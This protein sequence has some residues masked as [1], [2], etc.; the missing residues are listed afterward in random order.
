M[1]C[2]FS[3]LFPE[4]VYHFQKALFSPKINFI[5]KKIARRSISWLVGEGMI[6]LKESEKKKLNPFVVSNYMI[7][8]LQD[9]IPLA[10]Q[11]L[12]K[13]KQR[14]SQHHI[15]CLTPFWFHQDDKVVNCVCF[16]SV[17]GIIGKCIVKL[18][19]YESLLKYTHWWNE[20]LSGNSLR[21]FISVEF[22]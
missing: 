6:F 8:T 17:I 16:S 15:F 9:C 5:S 10:N 18:H 2:W 19:R 4:K 13:L 14:T 7:N 21:S 12:T 20:T 22:K 3:L 11:M 1:L